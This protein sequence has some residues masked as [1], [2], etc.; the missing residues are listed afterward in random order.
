MKKILSLL[1]LSVVIMVGFPTEAFAENTG[2]IKMAD[3]GWDSIRLHNSVVG[4]IAEHG[5]GITWEEVPG[6]TPITFEA[7]KNGEIDVYTEIWTD[8]LPSYEDD[9]NQGLLLDLGINF[10]DN[11]QGIYV[12][13][14]VIEGD[15]ER[16]IEPIAPDLKTVSDLKKYAHVFV[17]EENPSMGRIYGAIPG[18]EV[19]GIVKNKY[20]YYGL[21]ENYF[22][23]SPGSETALSAA[24]VAA[25]E[26][27]EPIVG[28]NWEPTW[29]TGLYDF[30][31][32]EDAPYISE[33]EYA[34][35][36]TEFPSVKIT[37]GVRPGFDEDYPE[38]T[39]FLSNYH[40]SSQLTANALG[41]IQE[42]NS[43]YDE[44]ALWFIEQNED[45][46]KDMMPADIWAKVEESIYGEV[47]V[48]TESLIYRFPFTLKIDTNQIDV[49][50]R[51]FA[52]SAEGALGSI[53]DVLNTLLN[54]INKIL[55]YIPW[56]VYVAG[57]FIAGYKNSKKLYVGIVY[58]L[59]TYFIGMVGLWDMAIITLS[60]IITS[61][62][63]SLL[64]GFPI[65]IL[66]SANNTANVIVRPILDA[67]QT[68]P[69]F[70]YLIPAVLLFGMGRVPGVIATV[71][72]AI[73]PIIRLTNL[74][75][76]QVD[77]EIVEAS[78]SFGANKFQTMFK[79]QIP[80]A[81]PTIMAGV[82][83]TLMMAMA[84]VVTTSMIGVTGLGLEVL[85]SVNR[86]EVGRGLVSGA[87]VVIIAIL[88][89]RISQG[90]IKDKKREV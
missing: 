69:I 45:L 84:M 48:N 28:Y 43:S 1:M 50:F 79:V 80:Q 70:V 37:V 3:A 27:G 90:W 76:R 71:I 21:D 23:F 42:T 65:G 66:I 55:I 54:T 59:L 62:I 56:W 39:A 30:T 16:G 78:V 9:V 81:F 13:T 41:Y 36:E 64:L 22:Y 15:L 18:W 58:A 73:V 63:I 14:Y 4:Y 74:G 19:D 52:K 24:F 82:N 29:L 34:A 60:I 89:D 51:N 87:A 10:D 25:Y 31:L 75:I 6:S 33:Q 72:Y 20:H 26:K 5:Y 77:P 40:T 11:A 46:I 35:G 61:V 44:A 38:F 83:Q 85:Y 49:S 17:D 67:M 53:R 12:P 47:S 57:A 2:H 7:L 86:I 8:N 88:L 68:M 32:L